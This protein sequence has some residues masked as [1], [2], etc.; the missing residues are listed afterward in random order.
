M[1]VSASL[2]I[3]IGALLLLAEQLGAGV[4]LVVLGLVLFGVDG[5][6]TKSAKTKSSPTLQQE[7]KNELS[8]EAHELL[9]RRRQSAL[10]SAD[11]AGSVMQ[12]QLGT[13]RQLS[14]K[15]LTGLS[16]PIAAFGC[17]L[18]TKALELQGIEFS[19]RAL[20]SDGPLLVMVQFVKK[21]LPEYKDHN[22]LARFV[23]GA[24]VED[25]YV[26]YLGCGQAAFLRFD[27]AHSEGLPE[28][29]DERLT[30]DT[31]DL[32]RALGI[33]SV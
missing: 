14:A 21:W 15:P 30:Q 17:G 7:P 28:R 8:S 18:V 32:A 26:K 1:K 3:I 6:I 5:W 27:A 10:F 4:G 2:V 31:D 23:A 33:A 29:S 19:E 22:E 16:E 24:G 11:V 25:K 13:A 20:G 9:I 12:A